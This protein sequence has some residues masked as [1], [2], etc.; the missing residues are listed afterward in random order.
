[1]EN[2][3][4][5]A[6][7]NKTTGETSWTP[8]GVY[9]AVKTPTLTGFTADK[10][11][12]A[13][14]H[15]SAVL[16]AMGTQ[17]KDTTETVTYTPTDEIDHNNGDDSNPVS[18]VTVTRTI[19]YDGAGIQT[20]TDIVQ[21][22]TY[23]AVTNVTTGETAWTPQGSYGTV[24]SPKVLGYTPSQVMVASENP[25]AVI[26]PQGENPKDSIV[27]VTYTQDE[28]ITVDPGNPKNPTDP[29]D[30]NKPD[31][32]K[33]PDGVGENDLNK[34]ISRTITYD[35][36]GDQ[37]P[38][39]VTQTAVYGRTAIVDAKTGEFLS[40]G[41][42]TLATS[43]DGDATDD[44]FT[45]VTSPKI[46]G[47][48]A[49]KSASAITLTDSE[50]SN[51]KAG[52]DDVA[53]TYTLDD[54]VEVTTPTDPTQPVDP[55]N[56]TGPK[57]P[58]I[59]AEDLN[60][61]VSR[62]I[63]YQINSSDDPNTSAAPATVTQTT[64]YKRSAIVDKVTG[65]VL[66]YTDWVVDGTNELVEVDSPKLENYVADPTSVAKVILSSADIDAIRSGSETGNFDQ[67]VDYTF[68][69]TVTK[70]T[71]PDGGT[72]TVTKNPDGDVTDI[73]KT[74]PDGDKTHVHVDNNTGEETV[75]ETPHGQP[76]LPTVTVDP[77][78]TVTVGRTTV[79]NEKP[80]GVVSMT[81]KGDNTGEGQL[82]ETIHPDGSITYSYIKNAQP[83]ANTV[84][85]TATPKLGQPTA[86]KVAVTQQA[87]K[88]LPQTDEHSDN[89]GAVVGM[90][91]LGMI[92][93]WVGFKR[94]K[95][96]ED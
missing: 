38:E 10:S 85:P 67:T 46:L 34:T 53:V 58:V 90:S 57:M 36:A 94:K 89:A 69:G 61:T 95:R 18:E 28:T 15:P 64:N 11:E 13:T 54:T 70:T 33:Y 47:Y 76:S 21:S 37:T 75:T 27:R 77:G 96:D 83:T 91:L 50:V 20:P 66:R 26:L 74:W 60:Q 93:G 35:G 16:L 73:N 43:D 52:S 55:G 31:G 63:T 2:V 88:K 92:L 3:V 41:D 9:D 7:T 5:K 81:H 62:T 19:Y 82:V 12:V 8:Q 42:W 72:T 44:G 14:G 68:N 86:K 30:P 23:K 24:T 87:N 1:M 17:P 25:E 80:N 59:T 56:P 51:F 49:D 45:G 4:Y 29:I 78:D 71:D 6:V 48:S 22:V 84:L 79:H 32:P 40:Y 65:E 39:D